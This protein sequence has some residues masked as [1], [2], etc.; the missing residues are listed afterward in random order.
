MLDGAGEAMPAL[1]KRE[2]EPANA[3]KAGVCARPLR[4][5]RDDETEISVSSGLAGWLIANRVSLAFTASQAGHLAFVGVF[6]DGRLSFARQNLTRATGLHYRSGCLRVGAQSQLWRLETVRGGARLPMEGGFD[7]VLFPRNAHMTGDIGIGDLAVDRL[8]RTIFVSRRYSCL[9]TL[10]P[11][12]RFRPIWK[13]S[14]IPGLMPE[15]RCRLNGLAM[16]EGVP[17]YVTAL[18]QTDKAGGWPSRRHSGGVLVDIEA[19]QVVADNLSM[20]HSPRV[21]DGAIWVLESGRGLVVRI[22]PQT[23]FKEDIVFCP[24]FLRGLSFHNG[25][26]IVTVSKPR[27]GAFNRLELDDEIAARDEEAR[28]GILI[29]DPYSGSI[30]QWIRLDGHVRELTDVTSLPEI[31]CPTSLGIETAEFDRSTTKDAGFA[32][33]VRPRPRP[34]SPVA[35]S[36]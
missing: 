31:R 3:L 17:K 15:D 2:D 19:D 8:G 32:P 25:Y 12:A 16:V 18:S 34:R 1:M 14:F 30:V 28:C 11:T 6:P 26:A 7:Q 13:P 27:D 35:V 24:G 33:S 36:A 21:F 20:P 9:A 10:S 5:R 4:S 29:I 22:D 23:G